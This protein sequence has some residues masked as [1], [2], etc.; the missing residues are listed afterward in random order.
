[1]HLY[2]TGEE[3]G[4]PTISFPYTK[5]A[6]EDTIAVFDETV[7]RIMKWDFKRCADNA[8]VCENRDFRH[9]CKKK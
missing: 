9:Y 2:Y 5:S 3:D 6:V 8:R 1:M 4:E 7:H